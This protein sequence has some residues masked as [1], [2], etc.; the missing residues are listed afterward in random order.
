MHTDTRTHVHKHA[1]TNNIT[2]TRAHMLIR[3]LTQISTHIHVHTCVHTT[4]MCIHRE[5]ERVREVR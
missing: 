3:F 2:A 4:H 5:R 1:R